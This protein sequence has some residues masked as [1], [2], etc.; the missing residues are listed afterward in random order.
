MSDSKIKH[1]HSENDKMKPVG[2]MISLFLKF[3]KLNY[4][5]EKG[6]PLVFTFSQI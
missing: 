5:E 3:E 1:P 2:K 6:G 4:F